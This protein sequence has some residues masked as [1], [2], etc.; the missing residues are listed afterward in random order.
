MPNETVLFEER[1]RVFAHQ[2]NLLI[3]FVILNNIYALLKR[4][5]SLKCII[6]P[7][8][9]AYHPEKHS[10]FFAYLLF[11]F[12]QVGPRS[13]VVWAFLFNFLSFRKIEERFYVKPL[14]NVFSYTL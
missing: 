11:I 3:F 7:T 6:Q 12:L 2:L 5:S 9:L 8:P 1:S 13:V 10:C 4:V 14:I